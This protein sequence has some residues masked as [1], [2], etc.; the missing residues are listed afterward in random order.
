MTNT[1]THIDNL[2]LNLQNLGVFLLLFFILS[3]VVFT[4]WYY[5][6][7]VP[8]VSGLLRR[9][10]IVL[11]SLALIILLIGLAEPIVNITKTVQKESGCSVLLDTSSSMERPDDPTRKRNALEA[12]KTIRSQLKAHAIY[13]AFD[14][15]V[16]NLQT[17]TVSF[18]GSGTNIMNALEQTHKND[19]ISSVILIS[20]GRWNLGHDPG[21]SNLSQDIPVYCVAVGSETSVNDVILSRISAASVGYD[22]SEIPV[23][24]HVSS[25]ATQNEALKVDILEGETTVASSMISLSQLTSARTKINLLL[26]GPGEHVY[27]ALVHPV[28]NE[29]VMNNSRSFTVQVMKSAFRIL[30]IAQ[31]P[32]PDL[33]FLRR[34]IES[35]DSFEG[36]FVV[37]D[38]MGKPLVDTLPGELSQFDAY[39]VI[40]GASSVI[41]PQN[42][43]EIVRY[44]SEGAGLWLLGSTPPDKG[45]TALKQALPVVFSS[46]REKPSGE[47]YM[48]LSDLGR[49]HFITAGTLHEDSGIDWSDLPPVHSISQIDRI[50][51]SGQILAQAVASPD[52]KIFPALVAGK[53][54]SGKTVV[55]PV[56]G[57]WRWHLMM[58]GAGKRGFYSVF[59]SGLLRWLTSGSESSPLTVNAESLNYLSGQEIVF[60]GRLFDNIYSPVSGAEISLVIDENPAFKLI[61]EEHDPAVY[62]GVLNSA[63]PG[64]HTF[65]ATAYLNG[66]HF[67]E[68]TGKFSVEE[69]SLEMLDSSPNHSILNSISERTGGLSVTPA[70]VDSILN[71]IQPVYVTERHKKDHYIALNPLM[72][73]ISLLLLV[74]EWGIR[75]HRGMI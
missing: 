38:T 73:L 67:A 53:Y 69:F 24:I 29:P 40:D 74:F 72:P 18:D 27:K 15:D 5:R 36:V 62:T 43:V 1:T 3:A 66:N 2:S 23:E 46:N 47:L 64:D 45:S 4:L 7:T 37:G 61:L 54:G 32:S 57:I 59:I 51:E 63:A 16:R 70:G 9:F 8:P 42:S 14:N 50:T 22:G 17:D 71:R 48:E 65:R 41:T 60:E 12:L 49:R 35:D 39:I 25:T 20:D 10:L 31:A 13:R 28:N 19:D 44:V 58:E 56:T 68:S 11:R 34:V 21:V 30:V 75:K 6:T 52:K 55:L 33:A 26:K